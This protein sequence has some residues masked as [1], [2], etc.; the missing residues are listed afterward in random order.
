MTFSIV[1]TDGTAAGVAVASKFLAVGSVVPEARLGSDG[2]RSVVV[3]AAATQATAKWSYKVDAVR[4]LGEGHDAAYAI[5]QVTAADPEREHRQLGVVGVGSQA[6]YTGHDCLSWAGG[7]S[8]ADDSGRYAIQ[9]NILVGEQ[10]VAEM[11]RAWLEGAGT[12]FEHRLVAA[13]LAGDAA[14]GDA[15]GRQSAALVVVAAGE[16]YDDSGVRADLRVDDHPQAPQELARLLDLSDLYFGTAEDVKPLTGELGA[17][18]AGRLAELGYSGPTAGALE[19]WAGV[20]N[21]EMRLTPDGIDARVLRALR[22]A[23]SH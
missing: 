1:A 20:E 6:T 18:V 13:L 21:Y 16:G 3:G 7:R 12:P 2:Q 5:Q 9:G 23:T 11:E 17:E 10:V 4:L 8:G 14:G 22:E 15:R 19:Q